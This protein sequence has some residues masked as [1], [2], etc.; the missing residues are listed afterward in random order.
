MKKGRIVILP[1]SLML[2]SQILKNESYYFLV[3]TLRLTTFAILLLF[4]KTVMV[5]LLIPAF[6]FLSATIEAV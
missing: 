2:I 5:K 1:P 6:I 3:F 4:S